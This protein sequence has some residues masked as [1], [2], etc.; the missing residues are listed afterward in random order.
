M[1]MLAN[2]FN[3]CSSYFYSFLI[4]LL[5]SFNIENANHFIF[6]IEVLGAKCLKLVQFLFCFVVYSLP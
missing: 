2:Y 3:E 6:S 1:D 5:L 4:L